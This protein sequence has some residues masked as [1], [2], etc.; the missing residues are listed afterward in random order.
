MA[1]LASSGVVPPGVYAS[2]SWSLPAQGLLEVSVRGEGSPSMASL[3]ALSLAAVLL[4]APGVGSLLHRTV[5][6]C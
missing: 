2:D 3:D 6:A 5:H 1:L 4:C